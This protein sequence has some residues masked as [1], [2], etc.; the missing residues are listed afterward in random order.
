MATTIES[1]TIRLVEKL[2]R[3]EREEV[4][5]IKKQL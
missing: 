1:G 2:R 5:K 3:K 4:A